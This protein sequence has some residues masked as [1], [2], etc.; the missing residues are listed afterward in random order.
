MTYDPYRRPHQP[1]DPG[2]PPPATPPQWQQEAPPRGYRPPQPP[3]RYGG[4]PWA[5]SQPPPRQDGSRGYP[6]Q[7]R[8][9][10]Q[11]YQQ[12]QY[13]PY[14]YQQPPGYGQPQQAQP[15]PRYAPPRRRRHTTRNVLAGL[16]GLVVLVIVIAVAVAASGGHT[17]QVGGTSAGSEAKAAVIGSA[18]TLAGNS[19]GEQMSITVTQVI[20]DAAENDGLSLTPAG[21]RLYAVQ[22]RL[23]NTGSAAYSDA[24]SNGA[25]VT[26]SAGQSYQSGLETVAGCTS[27]P[28]TENIA[29]GSSG[30]GCIVF[31]VP[32]NAKITQVQFTLD[33][34]MGP[35]TGQW[36]VS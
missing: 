21:D 28:A 7:P 20:A 8:L 2:R 6:Q 34:G 15:Y 1:Y 23:D 9:D 27:F 30:L 26:D 18:I 19:S 16:C 29:P 3:P 31:E 36:D 24:P 22:F 5:E 13:Q 33:S 12:P 32:E 4:D 11:A 25:A 10:P 14:G 17:I 35:D